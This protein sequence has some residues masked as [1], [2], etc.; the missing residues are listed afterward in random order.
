MVP[1]DKVTQVVMK[2]SENTGCSV[3]RLGDEGLVRLV[4][5]D[6]TT[7]DFSGFTDIDEDLQRRDYTANAVAWS[8]EHGL[9]DPTGGIGDIS[10]SIL[11]KVS[12]RNLRDDPVRMLRAYRFSA[13]LGWKIDPD[14]RA[15]IR[16]YH[17]G[18]RRSARERITL[19]LYKTLLTKNPVPSLMCTVKDGLL[20]DILPH[21][22]KDLEKKVQLISNVDENFQSIP[23]R[24]RFKEFQQGLNYRGLV[25]L[26]CLTLGADIR[27][28]LLSP[29]NR[30]LKHLKTV[31][32]L[33]G[34]FSEI[35]TEDM[36]R[37]FD[38]FDRSGEAALDLL[39]LT[40]KTDLYPQYRRFRRILSRPLMG[41]DEIIQATGI[42]PGPQVGRLL[43]T[44][45]RLQFNGKIKRR[46]DALRY[47]NNNIK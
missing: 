25:R 20:E 30:I 10:N 18:I 38:I 34:L 22:N 33:F 37:L 13:E 28:A 2:I 7:L 21:N 4:L 29:G 8:P 19:E 9:L 45:R 31:N 24:I 26:E 47:I 15:H 11:R 12:S 16:K 35:R 41:A 40:G 5:K 6:G 23:Q 3:V 43:K 1:Q 27:K 14:T 32:S 17:R 36:N 46:R 44:L 39:I 42:S